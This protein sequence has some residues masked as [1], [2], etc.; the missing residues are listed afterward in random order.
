MSKNSKNTSLTSQATTK[1]TE[2]DETLV[3]LLEQN[4]NLKLAQSAQHK[5][6]PLEKIILE[7]L[8]KRFR[9]S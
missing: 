9:K 3:L 1:K 4:L 6:L 8:S 2:H 7:I 5:D